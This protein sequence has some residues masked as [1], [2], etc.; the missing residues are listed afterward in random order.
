MSSNSEAR[1]RKEEKKE[2]RIEERNRVE[3]EFIAN[4]DHEHSEAWASGGAEADLLFDGEWDYTVMHPQAEQYKEVD[5]RY[6]KF[7]R[8]GHTAYCAEWLSLEGN[9]D[10]C[11]CGIQDN[12]WGEAT[13][14][15]KSYSDLS[16]K[17]SG[18]EY[19]AQAKED[20][21]AKQTD[22]DD[23]G[24]SHAIFTP[25]DSGGVKGSKPCQLQWAPPDA[26]VELGNVLGMGADKYG[27][28]N[29]RK[30]TD[31]S[32]YIGA[33]L[34]HIMAHQGGETTDPESQQHHLSHAACVLLMAVQTLTDHGDKY[35]D[36]YVQ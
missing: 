5:I 22:L 10:E 16:R 9:D 23:T 8:E 14:T 24:P 18:A 33:A 15:I 20:W 31:V 25:S 29:Y 7:S 35:D 34:R 6:S 19:D 26:M 27:S 1:K 12:R 2:E 28:N 13:A 17:D 4:L 11:S 21:R 30:G 32:L 36:R 3:R